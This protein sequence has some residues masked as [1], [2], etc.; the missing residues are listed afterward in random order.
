MPK[1]FANILF[2]IFFFFGCDTTEILSPG[3]EL[4]GLPVI[5]LII[6]HDNLL[7][8]QN[9]RSVN[10]EVPGT[11]KYKGESF[12]CT[13]RASGAGSRYYFKWSYR[14]ELED[15]KSIEG[16]T[17]FNLSA[18]VE[19]PS[20]LRTVVTSY[21]FER[22]GFKGFDSFHVFL[23]LNNDDKGLY[24]LIE[25]I[26]GPYFERRELD[27]YELYKLGFGSAFSFNSAN[28][29]EMTFSK[30]IPDDEQYYNLIQLI[31]AIDTS[32]SATLRLS[33][34]KYI[35]LD[36][37]IKYHSLSSIIAHVDG[38]RNNFYLYKSKP[39]SAFEIIPW[40]FDKTFWNEVDAAIVG[41]NDLIKK[42][43]TNDELF[44]QYKSTVI[45]QLNE[46]L[47]ED[48]LFSIIDS[49]ALHIKDGYDLDSYLGNGRY[50]F[51]EEI[52]RLKL[53]IKLRKEY[54]LENL[55]TINQSY[56]FE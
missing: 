42:I 37:Y 6:E 27:V 30:Q 9:N 36:N 18:Q 33:L 39:T 3:D 5:D 31:N 49:T 26:K 34:G 54:L 16:L 22:A 41:Y 56:I 51:N 44:L 14:I 29:P 2:L 17:D 40:D 10:L 46:L 47:D 55:D 11:I 53:I 38:F 15:G 23:Q 20:M 52:S 25:I 50:N 32:S 8:L 19:D 43:F 4:T 12:V 13:V 28:Y 35:D 45:F 1:Y 7:Q 24:S 21:L 48:V